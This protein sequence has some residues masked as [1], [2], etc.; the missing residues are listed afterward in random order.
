VVKVQIDRVVTLRADVGEGPVWDPVE[1][2]LWWTD[3][4]AG[5]LHRFDPET[6]TDE[7]FEVGLRVGCFAL[8]ASGG[9]VL[10]AEKGFWFWRPG[11]APE[12]IVDVEDHPNSRMNDGGCDRQGRFVASSMNMD[13][14]RAAT[15]GCWR[16]NPD[17]S[18]E[19]LDSG[20]SIGNGI[21][22]SPA[23]DKFYLA[24]TTAGTVWVRD[25]NPA[26]GR[27]GPRRIFADLIGQDGQPD[28][29][30]VDAAGGYWLA[31]VGGGRLCR[32]DPSGRLD[33]TLEIPT[34][35][36]TRPMFGGPDLADI[37][38]TSIGA[39]APAD[40][41]F[42][43]NLFRISGTGFRGLPEPRFGDG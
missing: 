22:F 1:G 17:L 40:D 34:R 36:P 8:R 27:L 16:L 26:T 42:A 35:R 20:L 41:P 21:A 5:V 32:F 18:A 31:A 43:G 6:G 2:V 37:Y 33:V 9:F 24:D 29:A 38:L 4:R 30:T 13:T 39:N 10:G 7:V 11:T 23:G 25:L 15:A 12:H 28:G 3:I 14:P 19:R